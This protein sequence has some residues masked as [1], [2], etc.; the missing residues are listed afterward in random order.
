MLILLLQTYTKNRYQSG[1]PMRN[2]FRISSRPPGLI[3][4][5]VTSEPNWTFL[6]HKYI[7]IFNHTN[8]DPAFLRK[9]V[10]LLAANEMVL[11]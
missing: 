11:L 3:F 9:Q 1:L 2:C 6:F 10:A 4:K 7:K 5:T 8:V